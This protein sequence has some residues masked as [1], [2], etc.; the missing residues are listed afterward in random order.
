VGVL[1]LS[2]YTLYGTSSSG[3]SYG[4]GT[5]FAVHTDGTGF[6]TLHNFTAPYPNNTNTDGVNP[7]SELVI[8]SNTMFGSARLGGRSGYGT[9]FAMNTDGTDFRTL[10]D[11]TAPSIVV[12][13]T[14]SDGCFPSGG[15]ALTG[16]VLYGTARYGG[17]YS[18][19]G[20][21]DANGTIFSISLPASPPPLTVI[22]VGANLILAWPTNDAGYT[23]ESTTNLTFPV[24]TTNLAAPAVI[25]SQFIVTNPTTGKQQFF[26]L[27]Q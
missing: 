18:G 2:E 20:D 14:N 13:R 17:S 21:P 8:A 11:F 16:S 27:S 7:Q 23:L 5:I 22:A 26:R 25:N 24:W 10:H 3:G 15:L 1:N 4:S 12:P 9:I 6:A 19:N